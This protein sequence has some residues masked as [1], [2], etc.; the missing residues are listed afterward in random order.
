MRPPVRLDRPEEAL[1]VEEALKNPVDKAWQHQRLQAMRM[2]SQ[3][4]WSLQQIAD[5]VGAGRSSVAGWLK[6]VREQGASALLE[7]KKGQGAP[8]RVGPKVQ[9]AITVGL[10][11][12]RWRHARDLR[13]WLQKEHGIE[14]GL[15][16][17]Y[18]YLGKVGGVLKVPRK[19][20]AKK[21]AAQG[22]HFKQT[23]A[24]ELQRLPLETGRPVRVWV[25]DEHRFGLISVVRRC[26]S[27]RGERVK[28]PYHTKYQ[29]GYLHSALE[30]DGA[31]GAQALF[32]SS[33]NLETSGKFLEQIVQSD[34]LCEHVVIWDQAGFHPRCGDPTVP[35]GVHLISLPPYSPELNPVEKLG[36]FIKDAVANQVWHTLAAIEDAIAEE[37]RPFW[38][39]PERVKQLIGEN[40]LT[41]QLN[42]FDP[43]E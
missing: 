27:L 41:A 21:D 25:A 34:P 33:V 40:W 24:E 17:V 18:Y 29:W 39:I 5:A 9:A 35:A 10:R 22:E 14:I 36:S 26:W 7:R 28:A 16:G 32:S 19:T 12:G 3:G 31:H 20:H 30:V 8:G 13:R 11:E 23:L 4:Q 38:K 2:A 1:K 15:G 42:S 6:I 37:L 43:N